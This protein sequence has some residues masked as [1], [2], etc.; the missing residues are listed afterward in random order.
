M[1]IAD[2]CSNAADAFIPELSA[3]AP[4]GRARRG[5]FDLTLPLTHRGS[6]S[7]RLSYEIVGPENAPVLLAAGGISAGR[8]VIASDDFAEPGWWQS[9]AGSFQL[10][11]YRLLSIDWIGADGLLD[12]PVDPA[13]QAEA[14]ARLLDY[15]G[16]DSFAGFIG[17]SYGAMV[18]M[19]FA[20]RYPDRCGALLA[21]SASVSAHPYAS[22]CRALQR[23]ALTLGEAHGDPKSGVALARA[24]AIL[25]YR[26][27]QEFAERFA[28]APAIT[29]DRLRVPAEDYLDFQGARLRE[30]MCVVAYRRLSESIDL[31]RIEADD[32][33]VPLTLVAVDQDA[34]VP[35][36]DI[37]S[38]ARAVPGATCHLIHS[39]YGH[40]AFLKEE[41]QVA[42]II[43]EFLN[44]LECPQ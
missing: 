24:M 25:T 34:L 6:A 30:R 15:R 4:C 26:T 13:D 1:T 17:A 2:R 7:V 20:A 21:I 8:H 43:T 23:Q 28:A 38:L 36:A 33:R 9:Q 42:A 10:P 27:P 3:L 22:A 39:R 41:A 29:D 16:I 19:H 14:I 12:R 18:G 32:I 37:E 35:A 5:E 31:H 40:D 11:S 44:S